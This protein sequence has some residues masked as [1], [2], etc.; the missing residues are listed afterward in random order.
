[1]TPSKQQYLDSIRQSSAYPTYRGVIGLIAFLF[2]AVAGVSALSAVIGDLGAMTRSFLTG[3]A[4]LVIG[5]LFAAIFFLM[6]KF[7]KEAALILADIG[8]SVV[9]SNSRNRQGLSAGAD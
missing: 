7:Y 2:Y 9:E 8:D 3:L 4:T 5:L 1:M 6:A